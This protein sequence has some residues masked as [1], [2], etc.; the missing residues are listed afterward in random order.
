MP[1]GDSNSTVRLQ[2]IIALIGLVGVLGAALITSWP[3]IAGHSDVA[4]S[5]EHKSSESKQSNPA[6]VGPKLPYV[7]QFVGSWK[8]ENPQTE[9]VTRLEIMNPLGRV[10]IHLWGNCRPTECDD[11][12]HPLSVDSDNALTFDYTFRDA[13]VE[14]GRLTMLGEKKLQMTMHTKFID[15]SGRPDYDSIFHFVRN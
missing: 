14:K 5:T 8:N 13:I 1:D 3:K 4:V 7:D 6:K 15:T 10:S 12:V 9:G 11:G 2:I